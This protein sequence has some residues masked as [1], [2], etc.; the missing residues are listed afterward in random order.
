MGLNGFGLTGATPLNSDLSARLMEYTVV[1]DRGSISYNTNFV[2][3][4]NKLIKEGWKPLG[5]AQMIC[6]NRH[7]PR[8]LVFYQTMVKD[9]DDRGE[10]T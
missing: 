4:V 2:K 3:A 6:P 5:P 9:E 1:A 7:N 10:G 8:E